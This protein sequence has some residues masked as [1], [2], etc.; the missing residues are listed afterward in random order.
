[1]TEQNLFADC[2]KAFALMLW[3]CRV[4]E[5]EWKVRPLRERA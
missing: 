1:M 2:F 4:A 5:R 3:H